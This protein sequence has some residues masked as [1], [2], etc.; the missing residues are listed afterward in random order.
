MN[1]ANFFKKEMI[2]E[3]KSNIALALDSS[4]HNLSDKEK[5]QAVY[6]AYLGIKKA[7]EKAG[8]EHYEDVNGIYEKF[9]ND[10]LI[11]RRE[12]LERLSNAILEQ[13]DLEIKF[14]NN[15][16]QE[17]PNCTQWDPYAYDRAIRTAFLEGFERSNDGIAVCVGFRKG[18]D[19]KVN[20]LN[21]KFKEVGNIRRDTIR[22]ASG[23]VHPEDIRFVVMQLPVKFFPEEALTDK[24]HDRVHDTSNGTSKKSMHVFRGF[25]FNE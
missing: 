17:Y 22:S 19:L 4:P 24:E 12:N 5:E 9:R 7:F 25:V 3:K 21:P 2:K 18:Q 13:Q 14:H 20:D 16:K 23:E 15:T 6:S 11:I 8:G 1:E 10:D